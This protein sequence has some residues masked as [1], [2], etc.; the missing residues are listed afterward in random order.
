[1]VPLVTTKPVLFRLLSLHI[2]L[3]F[4][5]THNLAEDN[6]TV[7]ST[8]SLEEQ[9]FHQNSSSSSTTTTYD[10]NFDNPGT[11]STAQVSKNKNWCG[12]QVNPTDL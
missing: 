11:I 3:S 7:F 12:K 8:S 1:M 6:M 4:F 9:S 2:C 10:G 5:A